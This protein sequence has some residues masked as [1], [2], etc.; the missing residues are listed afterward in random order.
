MSILQKFL[1]ALNVLAVVAL[2]FAYISPY[3]NP[4]DTRLFGVF[5]LGYSF[6]LILN[7][8]FVI[9]WLIAKPKVAL[10]SLMFIIFGF[11][12]IT[13]SIGFHKEKEIEGGLKVMSYNV[14]GTHLK[15]SNKNKKEN[16]K[17]F[18]DFILLEQPDII[19]MQERTNWQV[20][21]YKDIFPNFEN[22][23]DKGVGTCIYS[24]HP[25]K[26]KGVIANDTPF[27]NARWVDIEVNGKLLR[28]YSLHLS[29]NKV[30]NLTDNVKEIWD[31]S[32]YILNKYNLHSIRRVKQMEQILAHAKKCKH[33]VLITGDFN[34]VSQS[35]IYKMI[36]KEYKDTFKEHGHGFAKTFHTRFPGL[37]IDFAFADKRIPVLDFD[38]VDTDLSDH[39]PI[40]TTIGTTWK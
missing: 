22:Y 21:I 5:G 26:E 16:I 20:D 37:R 2:L 24:R 17:A 10:M 19:C 23:P 4:A 38:I 9:Y 11:S 12:S 8:L 27:N 36:A 25:I 7:A 6:I 34:D 30:T 13:N 18:K 3:V 40:V 39:Y 33:P 35:Y 15:F 1:Y 31:E 28:I 32:I 14:G 29:S